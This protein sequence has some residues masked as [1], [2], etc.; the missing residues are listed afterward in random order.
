LD[1]GLKWHDHFNLVFDK[2]KREMMQINKALSKIIGPS[3]KL[4]H[5]LYTGVIR[6]KITYAAHVWCGRIS[7][8]KLEKKS[9]QIQ[10]W[11]LTKLGPIRENTP[12]AG[13]EIITKTVPLHIHLQEVSLKT[14]YNFKNINFNLIEAFSPKGHLHRWLTMLQKYIPSANLLSDKGQKIIAPI[15]QNKLAVPQTEDEV[16]VYTDG[17][18]L[19]PDCG[20]GFF[21]RWRD[22]TRF[23]LGYNGQK[24][25]V[26]LSEIRAISLALDRL[27]WEKLPNSAV[28][29]YSD[30]QSAIAAILSSK[31]NSKA[32]QQCWIKLNKLDKI[33]KW[34][35]SWVKAHV[36]LKGN[37][38]ADKLAKRGTQLKQATPNLPI[39]PVHTIN[40]I[41][42]FTNTNWN[43]YWN[44]RIDCRQTKLW[45]PSPNPKISKEILKFNKMDFG[46][47]IRWFTGHCFLARH[48]AIIHNE[49]PTCNLCFLD[50]QTPW[51]L[52]KECPATNRIRSN[53]PHENWTA[54]II[55]KAIKNISYLEVFP[56]LII[57]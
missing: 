46:T 48:E 14:I 41:I 18:K 4:T 36:G 50:E 15:F 42:K 37:E 6:P 26:F 11:A 45:F 24:Y 49:D 22:Q 39:A 31:S 9:R 10:R 47:M 30:S 28:N 54:G 20:S 40:E 1:E 56:E 55:L 44:G 13:L 21:I 34:S 5:W 29:I 57:N 17:S 32:V 38:Q 3:P 7:N 8:Y 25:T 35:L 23:G 12:T 19:G 27:I 52:L 16:A 53:I 33:Y 2:A 43:T 51:H